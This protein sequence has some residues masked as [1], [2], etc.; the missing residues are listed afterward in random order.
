MLLATE[1]KNMDLNDCRV[2]SK[3]DLARELELRGHQALKGFGFLRALGILRTGGLGHNLATFAELPPSNLRM[4]MF[5]NPWPC[6]TAQGSV[7]AR[8]SWAD[9]SKS[10][11]LKTLN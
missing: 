7:L 9:G 5:A 2:R 8:P 11:K 3:K 6:S 1:H 4:R 10:S